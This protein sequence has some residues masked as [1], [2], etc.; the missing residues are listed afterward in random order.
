[1]GLLEPIP[2]V[3]LPAQQLPYLRL[4]A[5]RHPTYMLFV[6]CTWLARLWIAREDD[7]M[8]VN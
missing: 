4:M 3:L 6:A 8:A 2:V 1:M 7:T 5:E